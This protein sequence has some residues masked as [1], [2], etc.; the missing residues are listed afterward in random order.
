VRTRDIDIYTRREHGISNALLLPDA[1]NAVM[2]L[3]VV[4]VGIGDPLIT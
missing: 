4:G 1:M 3:A 2:C